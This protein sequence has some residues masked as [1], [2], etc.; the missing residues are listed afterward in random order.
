MVE[1]CSIRDGPSDH[2]FRGLAYSLESFIQ[3]PTDRSSFD[4]ILGAVLHTCG[5][6][7]CLALVRVTARPEAAFRGVLAESKGHHV[8][9][10]QLRYISRVRSAIRVFVRK[11]RDKD[12][13]P[14]VTFVKS[15]TFRIRVI[16]TVIMVF[17]GMKWIAS[18]NRRKYDEKSRDE[19]DDG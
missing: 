8:R 2:D 1:V 3:H 18:E 17:V 5:L 7:L 9:A 19:S 11:I 13:F 4:N 14:A 15:G 10:R 16:F 12:A 6:V